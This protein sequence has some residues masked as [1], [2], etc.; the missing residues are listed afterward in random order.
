V[1]IICQLGSQNGNSSLLVN[2]YSVKQLSPVTPKCDAAHS[3]CRMRGMY[4]IRSSLAFRS[5]MCTGTSLKPC[6]HPRGNG[7]RRAHPESTPG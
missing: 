1:G 4:R 3:F 2:F 7:T 6:S 5:E